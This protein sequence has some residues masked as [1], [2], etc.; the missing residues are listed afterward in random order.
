MIKLKKGLSLPINGEPNQTVFDANSVKRVALLGSDYVGMKPDLAVSVGDTVK[1][2]QLLFTDK[3]NPAIR[4]TS[5]GAGKVIEI[6]RGEKRVF[7]SIVIE[8]Q[9]NEERIFQSHSPEKIASLEREIII[10]QL[11]ESGLWAAI[12]SRPFETVANPD[13]I[14]HSIFITAMD[15][16]PLAPDVGIIVQTRSDEFIAGM[17]IISQLTDGNL[18]LCKAKN[19]DIPVKQLAKLKVEEFAGPH[20]SGNV[21]THIHFLNPVSRTKTVWHLMAQDVITI[22]HLFLNGRILT[23]RI[24]S[25]A[26]PSV[27]KPRLLKTRIGASI[28]DLIE[29]ELSE[30][31]QRVI[32]GSVFHGFRAADEF[33][34]LGRY[35]QQVTA[36]PEGGERQFFGW[37]SPGSDLYSVKNIVLSKL[38]PYKKFNFNTNLNGGV[39][40]IVPIGSYEK[41]MPLDILPTF[42]LRALA[43]DDIDEAEKLGCL[44]LAEED[45]AL[46][47]YVCPSK[48]EHGE[49]L[50][51]VLT[52]IEKEG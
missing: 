6:N 10:G 31:R 9:G 48:I 47:T 22:G 35:H 52:L 8:L 32:S 7:V 3:K 25:L 18:F 16:N 26:G 12:R 43:V 46:C 13:T 27:K 38:L 15:S 29:N 23:E 2:G 39:R 14:P 50:R 28:T 36:I 42:L 37:L 17:K 41:V 30:G 20:P 24:I 44:E 33:A 11:L 5:P 1:L 21:G 4:Y 49:N 40:C 45:L 34:F 51:R 19:S